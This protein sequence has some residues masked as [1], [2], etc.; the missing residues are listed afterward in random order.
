MK[1]LS[2]LFLQFLAFSSGIVLSGGVFA[3]IA[4]IGVV[5]RF[6]DKT[7]TR[8]YI[9][10]YERSIILGGIGGTLALSFCFHIPIGKI[11][12]MLFSLAVGIFVGCLAVSLAEILDVIPILTR[13]GKIAAGLP[14]F[15]LSI[16]LGKLAGSIIYYVLPGFYYT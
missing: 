3:L 12:V 7:G 1:V 9:R 6:A 10:H 15:M 8:D 16:A 4:S 11:G 13:R 14:F 2:L 5:P